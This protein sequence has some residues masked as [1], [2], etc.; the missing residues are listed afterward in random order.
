M[1]DFYFYVLI[2]YVMA[3]IARDT[4]NA[5][6]L[7]VG[8]FSQRVSKKS[9]TVH[10]SPLPT[11]HSKTMDMNQVEDLKFVYQSSRVNK[12]CRLLAWT[13]RKL[14]FCLNPPTQRATNS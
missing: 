14:F 9:P 8:G 3:C 1:S 2:V 13:C 7:F 12:A 6:A 10:M 4:Y 5:V 11:D